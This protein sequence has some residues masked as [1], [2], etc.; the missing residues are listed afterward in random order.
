MKDAVA[1]VRRFNRNYTKWTGLLEEHLHASRFGLTEA[2][3][4]YELAHRKVTT[5]SDLIAG[6]GV[7]AGYL[8]RILK[9]FT[10]SGY[11]TR[12]RSAEDG[13]QI[14]LALSKKG[15]AAFQP[16]NDATVA[17]VGRRA[18]TVIGDVSD[19]ETGERAAAAAIE[20]FGR[21]DAVVN[22]A[23]LGT[24]V[25][26]LRETP[27]QFRQVVEVNLNGA[28]WVAKSAAAVMEAGGS[29][30]NV[31]S[32]L[33]LTS[34]GLPQTAYTASKAGLLGLTRD[35]AQQWTGRLGIRVN[36]VL[37]GFFATEMTEQFPP[38]YF[39]GQVS[40]IPIGRAGAGEE[41]AA[42]IVFLASDA[43]SYITGASIPVDG[44]YLIV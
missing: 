44:G 22:N 1:A 18:V 27:E 34:G 15:E 33:A 25:P 3:I 23:G 4:L 39:E 14:N 32:V 30:I 24:A 42:A 36:A 29:I 8:S 12:E 26:A 7:D 40:S 9:D 38:G 41:L 11:I 19:P 21:L 16:L 31:S 43:S 13:R 17:A 5:A 2:R 20:E 6:L 35:L 10:K 28:Y 37:P